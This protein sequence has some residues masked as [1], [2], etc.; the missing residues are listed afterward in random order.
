MGISAIKTKP[1]PPPNFTYHNMI[2]NIATSSFE[3]DYE[4]LSD[5]GK[6][7]YAWVRKAKSR[8]TG[9]LRAVKI[10]DRKKHSKI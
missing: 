8:L 1:D 2:K 9:Q 6:G 10:I 7:A 5:L 3:K 4:V